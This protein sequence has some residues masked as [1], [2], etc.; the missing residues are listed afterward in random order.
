LKTIWKLT[1]PVARRNTLSTDPQ[2]AHTLE[3]RLAQQAHWRLAPS[4]QQ[5]EQSAT[6]PDAYALEE[7]QDGLRLYSIREQQR[8]TVEG[9]KVLVTQRL[10]KRLVDGR[11]ATV[12]EVEN[13][14]PA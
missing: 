13:V 10:T 14:R 11:W 6:D 3:G 1:A 9:R 8:R 4:V 2:V 12:Y 5:G 7:L